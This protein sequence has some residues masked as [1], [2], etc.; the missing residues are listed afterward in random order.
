[1]LFEPPQYNKKMLHHI[2]NSN[3][4]IIDKMTK[5]QSLTDREEKDLENLPQTLMICYLNGFDNAKQRLIDA[6]PLLKSF[7]KTYLSFKEV[8]RVLRKMKYNSNN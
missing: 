3:K 7:P 5:G 8:L 1:M 2:Y 4:S 6:K